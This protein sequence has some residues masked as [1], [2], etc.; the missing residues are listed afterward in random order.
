MR[1]DLFKL[2]EKW[3]GSGPL[4]ADFWRLDTLLGAGEFDAHGLA[5]EIGNDR[6]NL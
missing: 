3:H 2:V 6:V 5:E 4:W 1:R